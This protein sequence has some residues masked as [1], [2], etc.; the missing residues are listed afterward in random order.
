MWDCNR[1]ISVDRKLFMRFIIRIIILICSVGFQTEHKYL[2]KNKLK[3]GPNQTIVSISLTK[4]D[5]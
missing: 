3:N 4:T 2:E 5:N 1:L